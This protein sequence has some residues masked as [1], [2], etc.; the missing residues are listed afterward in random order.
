MNIMYRIEMSPWMDLER[1]THRKTRQPAEEL[2]LLWKGIAR[3]LE[4]R[5]APHDALER[6][7]RILFREKRPDTR[8][9]KTE[10]EMTGVVTSRNVKGRS[11]A[12]VEASRANRTPSVELIDRHANRL[13]PLDR[14]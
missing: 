3:K 13:P 5:E 7:L 14:Q 1:R 2:H 12:V 10:T 6:P 9:P 4:I 11:R 8:V